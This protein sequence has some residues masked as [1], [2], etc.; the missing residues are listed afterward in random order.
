MYH[1]G[2]FLRIRRACA[3]MHGHA[4]NNFCNVYNE[5]ILIYPINHLSRNSTIPAPPSSDTVFV[6]P[7]TCANSIL[8]E[9]RG[10]AKVGSESV[11]SFFA[12]V[13]ICSTIRVESMLWK[14]VCIL[15]GT[16]ESLAQLRKGIRVKNI[17]RASTPQRRILQG[18]ESINKVSVDNISE[19]YSP[20][21]EAPSPRSGYQGLHVIDSIASQES[22]E[23][24]A[25]EA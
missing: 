24:Y 17:L 6:I 3:I 12:A 1:L 7:D 2:Y 9:C 13:V 16:Q 25:H 5:V 10:W 11:R 4:Q 8:V 21:F 15:S 14:T 22:G 18:G 23:R 19:I 20:R